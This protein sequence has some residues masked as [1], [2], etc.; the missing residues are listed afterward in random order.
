MKLR[1]DKRERPP[2]LIHLIREVVG[3]DRT[4]VVLLPCADYALGTLV[5]V[6]RKKAG[7][8]VSSLV[9]TMRSGEK[10]LWDQLHRCLKTYNHTYLIV[11]GSL[12]AVGDP[13]HC[14]ADGRLR[15]VPYLAVVSALVRAEEEGVTVLWTTSIEETALVLKWLHTRTATSNRASFG[16]SEPGQ[17]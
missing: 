1:I 6:E 2:S 17:A 12:T 16:T 15:K 7:N 14:K 4:E 10:E 13:R 9:R 3:E 8:L 11:E 5:G